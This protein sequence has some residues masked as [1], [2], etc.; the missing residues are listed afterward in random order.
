[1]NAH[2]QNEIAAFRKRVFHSQPVK[3]FCE[4]LAPLGVFSKLSFKVFT[5]FGL[6]E[7]GC[8]CFLQGTVATKDDARGRSQGGFDY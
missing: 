7:T 3:D 8:C 1:M 2:Q 6:L 4:H 5:F